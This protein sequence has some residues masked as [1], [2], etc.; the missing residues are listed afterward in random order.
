MK[1]LKTVLLSAA[2]MVALGTSAQP[3]LSKATIKDVV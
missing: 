1:N 2:C 3:K